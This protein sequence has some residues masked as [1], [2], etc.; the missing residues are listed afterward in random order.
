MG[1]RLGVWGVG[2]VGEV[3]GMRG[4]R[5]NYGQYCAVPPPAGVCEDWRLSNDSPMERS[6]D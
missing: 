4:M 2:K 5:V 3:G 6:G 1:C